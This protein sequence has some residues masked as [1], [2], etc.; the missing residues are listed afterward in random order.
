MMSAH[1]IVTQQEQAMIC[2]LL[3]LLPVVANVIKNEKS[4]MMAPVDP[5][6]CTWGV[7]R[8]AEFSPLGPLAGCF[9]AL[10][11]DLGLVGTASDRR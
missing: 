5:S 1:I 2:K 11:S 8:R 4:A 9:L 7:E 3:L 6:H 10:G